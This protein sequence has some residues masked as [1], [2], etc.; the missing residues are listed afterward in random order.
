MG[1]E[2]DGPDRRH[3]DRRANAVTMDDAQQMAHGFVSKLAMGLAAILLGST[4][5]FAQQAYSTSQETDQKLERGIANLQASDAEDSEVLASIRSN[6]E[7]YRD[8]SESNTDRIVALE[9]QMRAALIESARSTSRMEAQVSQMADSH[10]E[11]RSVM[12]ELRESLR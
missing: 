9:S 5:W 10:R 6:L 12:Q 4:T 7:N 3:A 1:T 11:M 8:R 2:W